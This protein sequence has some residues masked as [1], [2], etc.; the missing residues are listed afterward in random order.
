MD[1]SVGMTHVQREITLEMSM[2]AA[3]IERLVSE[4]IEQ[5]STLRLQDDRGRVLF[6]PAERLAYV[7]VGSPEQRRVGFSI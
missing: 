2:E 7:L 5:S 6:V 3:E 4:S 1:V